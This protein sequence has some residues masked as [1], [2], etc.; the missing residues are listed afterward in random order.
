MGGELTI[1]SELG[2]GAAF[3]LTLPAG[4]LDANT[5]FMRTREMPVGGPIA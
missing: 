1:A 4:V 5:L 3:S 2:R